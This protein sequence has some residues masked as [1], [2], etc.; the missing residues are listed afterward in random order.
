MNIAIVGTG[1]V[2][3]VSGTCFAQMGNQVTCVDVDTEK[4][5]RLRQLHPKTCSLLWNHH[6][7]YTLSQLGLQ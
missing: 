4:I 2:G 7:T 3:L 1:Y 5:E 6:H